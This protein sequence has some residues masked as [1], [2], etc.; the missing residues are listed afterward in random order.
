[1]ANKEYNW[2]KVA[3]TKTELDFAANNIAVAELNGKKICIGKF[4]DSLFAFG[5][6]CPHAGGIL[7]N[8][9][10]DALGN[11][12]CPMHRYK[13]NVQ[14]GRNASGEGYFLQHWPVEIKENGVFVG[15]EKSSGWFDWF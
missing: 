7:A 14:T 5:Y 8:G 10:L 9:H 3:D 2:H 11:V 15:V 1:M 12:V 6:K 4:N 13:F